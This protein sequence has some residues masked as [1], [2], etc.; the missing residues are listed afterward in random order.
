MTSQ[1]ASITELGKVLVITAGVA[2]MMND[3]SHAVYYSANPLP[4]DKQRGLE[5]K[6]GTWA[7]SV[8]KASCP[9]GDIECVERESRLLSQKRLR[10]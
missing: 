9:F 1:V 8:A 5:E 2:A 3:F 7:V 4:Y 6:Y 10:K